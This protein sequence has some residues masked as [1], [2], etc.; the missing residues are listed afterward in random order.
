[1]HKREGDYILKKPQYRS[2]TTKSIVLDNLTKEEVNRYIQKRLLTKNLSTISMM[3]EKR[4][5]DILYKLSKGNFRTIKKLVRT[6]CQ[7]ADL[8]QKANLKRY[9]AVNKAT[10]TMAAIDIGLIDVKS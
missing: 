9:N 7:I 2:R 1:M 6:A 8:S 10:L 3:F 4:E 5:I